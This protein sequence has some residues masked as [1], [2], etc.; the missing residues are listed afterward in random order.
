[1]LLNILV[2]IPVKAQDIEKIGKSK[3]IEYNGGINVSQVAYNAIG[4]NSRRDPYSWVINA[5]LNL[6]LFGVVDAPFS[7]HFT[8]NN[9]TY[10]QPSFNHY[11]ISPKYKYITGHFGYR[12]MQ[13]SN[14]SLSGITFL[15][16]GIEVE[17]E[18]SWVKFSAMYGRFAKGIPYRDDYNR[19]ASNNRFNT[20]GYERWGYGGK[21]TLGK[22][23]HEVGLIIFRAAD[24]PKS[25]PDPGIESGITPKENFVLGLKTSNRVYENVTFSLEYTLSAYSSDIRMP[26]R[27]METFTY[28][29]NLGPLYT[30]RYSS[31]INGAFKTDVNYQA[32]TYSVGATYK[33]VEPE[34]R[35]LGTTYMSN[36]VEDILLNMSKSLFNNK[37]NLSGNIGRQRNNLDNQL[38]TT[39]TRVIG[40]LN[41][42]YAI[43]NNL[44]V[45]ANY[46]NFNASTQPSSIS[47]RDTFKYV[48]VTRN[49]G[50]TS[51]Y[52]FGGEKSQNTI[53]LNATYQVV[54]TLNETATQL[55]D[56]GTD[57]YNTNLGY[58]YT[59]VPRSL[60]VAA[61]I[62]YNYFIQE[63]DMKNIS[64]GPTLSLSKVLF[65]KTLRNTVSY[66]YFDNQAPK[67]FGYKMN[68]IRLSASYKLSKS[69]SLR[70]SSSMMLK[71]MK[72]NDEDNT[73]N[74]E[75]RAR[76]TY[77][78][79]F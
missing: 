25:I 8:K 29:N 51:N 12:S 53:M 42:S 26:E 40:G 18:E 31:S 22:K 72:N 58:S 75:Y 15:G 2:L 30:P 44:N 64:V 1:M 21:V 45:S 10:D 68:L 48:Q 79:G 35:S 20:P 4:M 59:F 70:L 63:K 46:S 7:A 17:P 3:A 50:I 28:L 47:V 78:Y 14:Y 41:C 37:V 39:N 60:T 34:Y 13:F 24:D 27:K 11:G 73:L 66:S 5:N 38:T 65:N 19:Y 67:D 71:N 33:R 6:T 32:E 36:D 69:Q 16:G 49:M 77:N 23:D 55:R 57:L 74:Q 43:S 54:N 56:V 9:H 62:N 52:N 61:N 76:L